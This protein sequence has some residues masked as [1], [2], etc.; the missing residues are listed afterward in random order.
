MAKQLSR[1]VLSSD[2]SLQPEDLTVDFGFFTA[3][4]F[5]DKFEQY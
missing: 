4:M 2:K 3:G 1:K 5:P